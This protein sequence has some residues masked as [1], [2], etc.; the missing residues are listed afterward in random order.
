MG[1]LSLRITRCN[2]MQ[3][4]HLGV[5]WRRLLVGSK[6]PKRLKASFAD[7]NTGV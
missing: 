2:P 4:V 7:I 5:N 3:P 1:A 6:S